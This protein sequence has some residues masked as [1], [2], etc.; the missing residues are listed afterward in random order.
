MKK[1][2]ALIGF[3]VVLLALGLIVLF[4]NTFLN[5]ETGY[6]IDNPSQEK[7]VLDISNSTFTI[8][9][10]QT[11]RVNLEKGKHTLKYTYNNNE[12]DTVIT[13]QKMNGLL[14]PTGAIYY[15]FNRPYG[16]RENVDSLFKTNHITIDDKVYYGKILK[17]D[18]LYIENFYYNLDEKFPKMFIKKGDHHTDLMKIFNE[19]D[20]KQ[21]YFENYE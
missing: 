6:V 4:Y 15:T 20:F 11:L 9:P 10:N 5:K 18:R 21:F 1:N 13:I 16:V 2:P 8:A 3:L 12:I 17:S 19:E 7:L 14:N